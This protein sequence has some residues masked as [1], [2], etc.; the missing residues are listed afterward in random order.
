MTK[1][2]I[3]NKFN[4]IASDIYSL[5]EAERAGAVYVEFTNTDDGVTYRAP[6]CK[7]WDL[8]KFI[9]FGYG[10]QQMLGL[11]HFEHMRG[12]NHPPTTDT[13]TPVY[14]EADTTDVKPLKY[15]SRATIGVVKNGVQQMTLFGDGE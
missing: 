14:S 10:S 4:S 12:A 7:F 5:H 2:H 8:G 1:A 13:E 3:L 11:A 6:I 9:D 15:T